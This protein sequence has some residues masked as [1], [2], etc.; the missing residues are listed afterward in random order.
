[1]PRD[2]ITTPRGDLTGWRTLIHDHFVSLAIEPRDRAEIQGTVHTRRVGWLGVSTVRSVDQTFRR[3]RRLASR[4][5]RD[6]LQVGFLKQ[7]V[8][9]VRQDGRDCTLLPG[10][11]AI[12]DTS[13]AFTW[14]LTGTWELAVFTWP[15]TAVSVDDAQSSQVTAKCLTAT[16][17]V[18]AVAGATLAALEDS[19]APVRADSGARLAGH[20]VDLVLTAALDGSAD[21]EVDDGCTL[22]ADIHDYI[23]DNIADANLG[24]ETIARA[25]YLSPR[26]L[27]RSFARAGSTVS[28][29]I[30][31]RRL[32][33]ARRELRSSGGKPI[34]VIASEL[35]YVD[36]TS[37]SRLFRAEYGLCPREYRKQRLR[38]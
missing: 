36:A 7:G 9:E 5:G 19:P 23:E 14:R 12:Y 18:G 8:A 3:T 6:L 16:S 1:M 28:Q 31:S 27:H 21:P 13:R 10:Q 20:V 30:R 32:E 25:F 29:T 17:T 26:T 33:R 34:A 38:T 2:G 15:R 22:L 11:F 24:P 35:G 4:D 37:F